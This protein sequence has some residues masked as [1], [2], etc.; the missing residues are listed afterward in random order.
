MIDMWGIVCFEDI[1]GTHHIICFPSL[2]VLLSNGK[3][4]LVLII[5]SKGP[6]WFFF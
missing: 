1:K 5:P 4:C 3:K 2:T 6:N